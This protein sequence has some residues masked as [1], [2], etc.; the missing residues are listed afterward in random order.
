[1]KVTVFG[2]HQFDNAEILFFNRSETPCCLHTSP[3]YFQLGSQVLAY[4][5]RKGEGLSAG[6]QSVLDP[7]TSPVSKLPL[8]TVVLSV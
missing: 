1:M 7:I 3:E 4:Q 2:K 6:A 5:R 8:V